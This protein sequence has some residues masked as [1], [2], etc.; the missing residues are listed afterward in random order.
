MSRREACL[1]LGAAVVAAVLLLTACGASKAGWGSATDAGVEASDGGIS[2]DAPLFPDAGAYDAPPF[3]LEPPTL[4]PM[5]YL[6]GPVLQDPVDVYLLWYGAWHDAAERQSLITRLIQELSAS[7]WLAIESNME[8]DP[9]DGGP[10]TVPAT[11]MLLAAS[12]NVSALE[13]DDSGVDYNV[14]SDR[15]MQIVTDAIDAGAVPQDNNAVYVVLT[16]NEVKYDSI[17]ACNYF[18]AYHD[19]FV[20]AVGAAPV[21][22]A[23]VPDYEPLPDPFDGGVVDYSCLVGCTV[24]ST[25]AG[26]GAMAAP[27][28]VDWAGDGM[29]NALAH[30]LAEAIDDPDP[31]INPAWQDVINGYVESADKC[32]WR[33]DPVVY[34]P[35][36]YGG[37]YGNVELAP[38]DW[39]LIQQ[40][41]RSDIL[42]P[43]GGE[44]VLAP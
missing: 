26:Y 37:S 14:S 42:G 1:A 5:Q 23:Y 30:E 13:P 40:N 29:A 3:D 25:A 38:G 34:L 20:P 9:W 10:R 15:V 18:C 19:S 16:S 11:R 43:N 33:F 4:G 28:S 8:T 41:W 39:W 12:V 32:E 2:N 31:T 17:N 7:P 22:Y 27:H 35:G 36:P 44:C 24:Q 21:R 6:G